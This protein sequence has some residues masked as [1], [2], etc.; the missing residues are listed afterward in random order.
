MIPSAAPYLASGPTEHPEATKKA[1]LGSLFLCLEFVQAP[2]ARWYAIA[3][4]VPAWAELVRAYP[5]QCKS[6][7]ARLSKSRAHAAP[8]VLARPLL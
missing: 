2:P 6:C 8:A 4:S 5:R 7:A 3:F 1:T